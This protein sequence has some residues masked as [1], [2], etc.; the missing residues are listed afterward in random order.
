MNTKTEELQSIAKQCRRDILTMI[1]AAKSGHPGGSLSCID[2]LTTLYFG[3]I[4]NHDPK[5]PKAESRDHFVL[6][7]G[8]AAP[9]LY[10]VLGNAGYFDNDQFVTLRKYKSILQGHPDTLKCPGVEVSTGSLGQ[11][12]SIACGEALGLKLRGNSTD[13]VFALLGDGECQEGQVWEAMMFGAKYKL[14]NVIAIIDRNNLQIDG[15]V[16]D[17]MDLGD[18][19]AKVASFGWDVV[20]VNGHNFDELLEVFDS[21]K[22]KHEGK[23]KCIIANTTK[24]KGVSFMEDQ[25]GWHGKAPND[26]EFELALSELA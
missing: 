3:N 18:L 13:S 10:A 19:K 7:K 23:P 22:N 24:G 11:G 25:A 9:A 6:A 14:D 21:V 20:E 17:V 1:H 8:H 15:N 4:L 16:G 26:E 2:M 12:L 5:N